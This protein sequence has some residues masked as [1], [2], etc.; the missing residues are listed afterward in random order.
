MIPAWSELGWD[1]YLYWQVTD[2]K[3]VKRINDLLQDVKRQLFTGIGVPNPLKHNW[4][5]YGQGILI[6]NTA[7]FTK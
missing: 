5:S 4:S 3:T 6:V 7:W 1:N 2:K